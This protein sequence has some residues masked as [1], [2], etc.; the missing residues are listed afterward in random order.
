MVTQ[1]RTRNRTQG[2]EEEAAAS[3]DEAEASEGKVS[4]RWVVRA[5]RVIGLGRAPSMHR[6]MCI[7]QPS[8]LQPAADAEVVGEAEVSERGRWVCTRTY[9]HIYTRTRTVTRVSIVIN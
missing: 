1:T 9:T 2:A 5:R 6:L 8:P 3:E 4:E 7:G